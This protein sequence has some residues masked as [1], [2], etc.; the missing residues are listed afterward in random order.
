MPR[1]SGAGP[2]IPASRIPAP[3][4]PSKLR[5]PVTWA[6]VTDPSKSSSPAVPAVPAAPA[7]KGD[8]DA[9]LSDAQWEMVIPKMA[10][11]PGRSL[12]AT[13]PGPAIAAAETGFSFSG[14]DSENRSPFSVRA[15]GYGAI[16]AAAIGLSVWAWLGMRLP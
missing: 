6:Y 13:D 7:A 4:I 15:A 1:R 5:F 9:M 8:A 2:R 10:R 14:F 16:A 12:R 3:R 11:P